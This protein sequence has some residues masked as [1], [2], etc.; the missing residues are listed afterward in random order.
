MKQVLLIPLMTFV[1]C[2]AYGQSPVKFNYDSNGNRIL[3]TQVVDNGNLERK[4]VSS[5]INLSD[6]V[7][8]MTLSKNVFS[9]TVINAGVKDIIQMFVY[10]LQGNKIMSSQMSGSRC[11]M[12]LNNVSRKGVY[13]ITYTFH[14]KSYSYKVNVI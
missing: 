13:I 6:R 9:F 3:R 4:S 5:K 10:D 12:D 8:F 11:V 14:D 7:S 2:D 1:I